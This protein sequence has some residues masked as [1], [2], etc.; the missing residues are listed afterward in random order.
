MTNSMLKKERDDADPADS[1][2]YIY[3]VPKQDYIF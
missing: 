1:H 2:G 3:F